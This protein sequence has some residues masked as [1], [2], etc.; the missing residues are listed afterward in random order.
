MRKPKVFLVVILM[1]CTTF[2]VLGGLFIFKIATLPKLALDMYVYDPCGGCFVEI[3]PCKPCA[4]VEH[5]L[6]IYADLLKKNR[7]YEKVD[8]NMYSTLFKS[9]K[10]KYI[11]KL[12]V[13]HINQNEVTFPIAFVGNEYIQGEKDI[14]NNLISTINKENS[15]ISRIGRA[16]NTKP[17]NLHVKKV[18][19]KTVN[20]I[21]YFSTPYC[22]DCS[23]VKKLFDRLGSA[24]FKNGIQLIFYSIDDK[25]NLAL[26]MKYREIYGIHGDN[27]IVPAIFIGTS[28]LEGYD[29]ISKKLEGLLSSGESAKTKIIQVE[30]NN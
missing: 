10:Q 22:D 8:F 14:E 20:A 17:I 30:N 27:V 3:G 18:A 15:L 23:S 25:N 24:Y 4:L 16:F 28:Y 21:I 26:L 12:R 7:L 1:M 2:V 9:F 5:Y 19:A 13:Y 29:E 11:E 6:S